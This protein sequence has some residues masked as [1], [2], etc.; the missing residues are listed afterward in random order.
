LAPSPLEDADDGYETDRADD[1][2]GA[3]T[4]SGRAGGANR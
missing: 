4:D 2:E 1:G 3:K